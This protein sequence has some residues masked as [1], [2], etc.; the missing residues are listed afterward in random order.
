M[1]GVGGG[2]LALSFFRRVLYHQMIRVD[3][4]EAEYGRGGGEEC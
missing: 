3:S 1:E 4:E 2:A